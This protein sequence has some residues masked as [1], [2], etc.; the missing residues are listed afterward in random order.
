M[1]TNYQFDI[2]ALRKRLDNVIGIANETS[3]EIGDAEIA[4]AVGQVTGIPVAKMVGDEK[5]RL[6]NMEQE[7]SNRLIGQDFAIQAVA[8]AVRKARAGLKRA[9]RPIGSFLFLGPTG[10]GKTYLA[11]LL[12]EL[13]FDDESNMIRMDMSEYV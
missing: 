8:T 6:L 4:L 13:L 5:K 11:K 3:K 9:N 2:A 12:A 1:E 7:I 10:V